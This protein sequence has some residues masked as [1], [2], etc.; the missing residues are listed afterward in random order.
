VAKK[1]DNFSLNLLFKTIQAEKGAGGSD[2]G[3]VIVKE[4]S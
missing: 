3:A 4:V 2:Q 1:N